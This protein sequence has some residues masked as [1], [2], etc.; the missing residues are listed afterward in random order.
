MLVCVITA[1]WR[2]GGGLRTDGFHGLNGKG[3]SV[4]KA[5]DDHCGAKGS[6]DAAKSFVSGVLAAF[7]NLL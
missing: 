5:T 4:V 6:Q 3:G 7:A 2:L 1:V